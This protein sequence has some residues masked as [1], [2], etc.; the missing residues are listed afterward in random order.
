MLGAVL[1]LHLAVCARSSLFKCHKVSQ[2]KGANYIK[3]VERRDGV[4][5]KWSP[6]KCGIMYQSERIN[7]IRNII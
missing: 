6:T 7:T 2:K 3:G 5:K 4:E 1:K